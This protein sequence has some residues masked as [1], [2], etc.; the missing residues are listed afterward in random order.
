MG[1]QRRRRESPGNAV[2]FRSDRANIEGAREI[3]SRPQAGIA[4]GDAG[5]YRG[6]GQQH[7]GGL[8]ANALTGK[9][10]R[11]SEKKGERSKELRR[12][13]MDE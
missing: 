12:A 2:Y 11:K 6:P 7:P 1:R 5:G 4:S 10:G 3:K 9:Q 13:R 8:G